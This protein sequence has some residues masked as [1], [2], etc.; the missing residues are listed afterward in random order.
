M[1]SIIQYQKATRRAT[2]PNATPNLNK[3]KAM[4]NLWHTVFHSCQSVV[5]LFV[6]RLVRDVGLVGVRDSSG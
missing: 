6:A 3:S 2:P 4:R 5:F 1:E